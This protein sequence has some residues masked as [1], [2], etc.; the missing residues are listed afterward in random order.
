MSDASKPF[1][2]VRLG[3]V[4]CGFI[5]QH[6]HLPN[7]ASLSE[8]RLRALAELRPRLGRLVADRYDIPKLYTSH[9][10]LAADDE[11]EA[12]AVSADYAVQGRIAADLLAAGKH[13]FMEK[14][15]AIS[16]QQAE[17]IL[18]AAARGGSRL[19][20]GYMKRSDP[21]NMLARNTVRSWRTGGDKGRLLYLRAH[22]FCGD[23]V[24]GRDRSAI[25]S[26]DEAMPP[27]QRDGL[28]PAWLPAAFGPRYVSYL[29]QYTHNLN[30]ALFLLD[31]DDA[32]LVQVRSVD[33]DADGL[34]GIVVLDANGVRIAIES[35]QTTFHAWEEHTQVYFEGG[36]I[37]V[38]SPMLF[39]NPGQPRIEIYE[40]GADPQYRTP[41]PKPIA[42]WHYREEAEQFCRCLRSG[43][44]F[45]A[46]GAT[47]LADVRIL[48]KIYER[49]A[50]SQ[51]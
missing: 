14:P 39:A 40:G 24:A 3:Y 46:A 2:P 17:T 5:A 29:Q 21:A 19:M 1:A 37:H 35:A 44:P 12:V 25:I 26:T 34:T 45:P 50:A 10:E 13:V 38:H 36:W 4:G 8:C 18:E 15:M 11:I 22:G 7:F 33:L 48:E 31:V 42:A 47:A 6:I 43:E 27:P 9:L 32:D 30:L 20:V 51:A 49:H 23:W 16:V 41:I 28:L